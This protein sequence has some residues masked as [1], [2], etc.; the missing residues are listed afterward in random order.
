MWLLLE[1]KEANKF[2]TIKKGRKKE[3]PSAFDY[4]IKRMQSGIVRVA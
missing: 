3:C 1:E 4:L 2:S